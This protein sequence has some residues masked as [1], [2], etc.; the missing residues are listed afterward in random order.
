[1]APGTKPA[2]AGHGM[3]SVPPGWTRV[4]RSPNP[5]AKVLATGYD[6]K[7]R[8]QYLY[9]PRWVALSQRRKFERVSDFKYPKFRRV[10]RAFVKRRDLSKECVVAGMLKLM[11]D[12]NI[13]VGNQVYLEQNQSV[14]LTTLMKRHI[15]ESG[16]SGITLTFKGKSGVVH[17]KRV[18]HPESVSFIRRVAKVDG[19]YLFYCLTPHRKRITPEDVNGFLQAHVQEGITSKDIRTHSAN[20]IFEGYLSRLPE[21]QSARGNQRNVSRA[22]RHTAGK[23]GNTP[24]V[25]KGAYIAPDRIERARAQK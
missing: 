10:L 14:G 23:L 13:R 9:N 2:G 19:K 25:C 21:S 22:V 5:N 17:S 16:R 7:G 12:L 20:R 1:M 3:P 11:G 6:A 8:K 24:T 4:K 15:T 18:T